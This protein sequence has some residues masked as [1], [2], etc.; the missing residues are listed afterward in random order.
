VGNKHWRQRSGPRDEL[1]SIWRLKYSFSSDDVTR[2]MRA[3]VT[4]EAGLEE[5]FA[6]KKQLW[7]RYI[8]AIRTISL[9]DSAA[10]VSACSNPVPQSTYD[11][12]GEQAEVDP[13]SRRIEGS[14]RNL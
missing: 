3:I 1:R 14:I 12:L 8:V 5:P 7:M 9:R 2:P 6:I 11:G 13:R 10:S 4:I